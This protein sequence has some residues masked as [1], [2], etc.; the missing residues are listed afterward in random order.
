[1]LKV[2]GGEG[3]ELREAKLVAGRVGV[4][5]Q[6]GERK[7]GECDDKEGEVEEECGE[8]VEVDAGGDER[9]YGDGQVEEE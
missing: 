2:G 8:G 1:L 9:G 6:E 5:K 4:E 7:D 3:R